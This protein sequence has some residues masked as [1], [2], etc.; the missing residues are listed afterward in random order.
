M[1]CAKAINMLYTNGGEMVDYQGAGKVCT[2]MLPSIGIPTTAGTGSDAQ[3]YALISDS[4]SGIKMAC[5]D[6][7][8]LFR[9][10]ILDPELTDSLPAETAAASSID[11]VSHA[12][13]SF[14]STRRNERSAGYA[15][16]AWQRLDGSFEMALKTPGDHRLWGEMLI[17]AHLAGAAIEASMLGAAHACANPLTTRF[18]TTHGVAVALMLPHV[19]RYNAPEAG[20]QYAELLGQENG[21]GD[22]PES[23]ASR[24]EELRDAAGLPT[25]LRDAGIPHNALP[26]LAE[27]ASR[28]WT[29]GFNPR[30]ALRDD[31]VRLYEAAY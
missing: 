9:A 24:F 19:I 8:A 10:V 22:A 14:V 15:A 30:P 25:R 29:L 2:L 31:L 23:L 6:Q 17:A 26:E 7:S 13:E 21:S 28:Q 12:L 27:A 16:E 1:D 11:A 20:A 3:S 18:G 4:G 5:G